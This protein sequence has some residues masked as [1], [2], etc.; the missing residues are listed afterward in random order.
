M[1]QRDDGCEG[2][3]D[4]I[5]RLLTAIARQLNQLACSDWGFQRVEYH[6][7]TI[8]VPI[9]T[10]LRRA[11]AYRVGRD[12]ELVLISSGQVDAGRCRF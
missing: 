7:P 4:H 9:K 2:N 8:G 10:R 5:N 1:Q 11:T 3:A 6:S 12:V